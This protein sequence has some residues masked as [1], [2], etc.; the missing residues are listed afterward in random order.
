MGPFETNEIAYDRAEE[1]NQKEERE[2][3]IN[4]SMAELLCGP[5]DSPDDARSSKSLRTGTDECVLL[6]GGAHLRDIREHPG[7]DAELRRA[8][9]TGGDDLR[10][11]HC[12]RR[13]LH[14]VPTCVPRS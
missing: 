6:R 8:R 14:V 1:P 11:E 9:Y 2:R 10:E 5:N 12:P 13:D 3:V 4:L 7:L